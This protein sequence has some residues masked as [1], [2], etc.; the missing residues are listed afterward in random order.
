MRIGPQQGD[1]HLEQPRSA[2]TD[3]LNMRGAVVAGLIGGLI[4]LGGTAVVEHTSVHF[5]ESSVL[6]SWE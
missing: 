3:P 1:Q 4:L 5:K 6:I 2:W